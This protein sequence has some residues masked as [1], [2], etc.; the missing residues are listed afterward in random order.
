MKKLI[1]T[2]L[3]LLM[4]MG[5]LAGCGGSGGSGTSTAP[6]TSAPANGGSEADAGPGEKV[7]ITY[8]SRYSNPEEP[9][10]RFYM[11]VL[12]E[13]L[14]ENPNVTVEDMSVSD[15]DSYLAKLKSSVA[16]GTLPDLFITN[17]YASLVDL[18]KTGMVKDL[19]DLIASDAWTGPSDPAVLAPF[20]Y[21][22]YGID[23]VY[24]VPNQ[25]VTE[26]MFVNTKLLKENGLEVPET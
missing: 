9:R 12:E 17:S 5:M 23:G 7:T 22:N 13:F 8:L 4:M 14:A 11:Q 20:T 1:C 25:V 21:Q 15:S 3:A 2:A 10:S 24:G 6:T 16:A 19:S 18:V 26:Q